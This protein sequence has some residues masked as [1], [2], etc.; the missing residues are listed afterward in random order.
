MAMAIAAAVSDKR[1]ASKIG[2]AWGCMLD[3]FA[4]TTAQEMKRRSMYA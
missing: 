1:S 2:L 4:C 3:L